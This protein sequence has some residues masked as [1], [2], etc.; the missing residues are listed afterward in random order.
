MSL[1]QWNKCYSF[2]EYLRKYKGDK[3]AD[4]FREKYIKEFLEIDNMIKL[5][6]EIEE[7]KQLLEDNGYKVKLADVRSVKFLPYSRNELEFTA[8][9]GDYKEDIN[10]II[11]RN[12][13][14][15]IKVLKR[16]G[17]TNE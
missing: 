16:F 15:V 10:G 5:E 9:N 1:E 8:H 14:E 6:K 11:D 12:I 13:Q 17:L 2:E 7:A 3:V 4:D